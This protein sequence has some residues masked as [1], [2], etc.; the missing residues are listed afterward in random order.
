[1]KEH[2]SKVKSV[3]DLPKKKQLGFMSCIVVVVGA[4]I[5]AGIFFKNGLILSNTGSGGPLG[6]ALA[7]VCWLIGSIGVMAMALSLTEIVSGTKAQS[8]LGIA[9]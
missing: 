6:F 1:M 4:C 9:S 5:G 8:N 3:T 7:I 2:K